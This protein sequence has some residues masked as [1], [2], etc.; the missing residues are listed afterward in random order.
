MPPVE[1]ES[2]IGDSTAT[3]TAAAFETASM[4]IA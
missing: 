1:V 3:P 4:S 2:V